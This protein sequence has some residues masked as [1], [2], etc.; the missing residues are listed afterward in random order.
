MFSSRGRGG[1]QNVH[2]KIRVN[3]KDLRSS[4][5]QITNSH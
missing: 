2:P 3:K 4:D 1:G 5:K